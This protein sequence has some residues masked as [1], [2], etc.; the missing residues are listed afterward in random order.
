VINL[1][2]QFL[3]IR[4]LFM[5]IMLVFILVVWFDG[6]LLAGQDAFGKVGLVHIPILGVILLGMFSNKPV[7]DT[8]V[9][10]VLTAALLTLMAVY[11]ATESVSG[12][13]AVAAHL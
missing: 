4:A 3:D 10:S 9:P 1:K 6:P 2:D 12:T 7:V 8:I 5:K 13:S 11:F